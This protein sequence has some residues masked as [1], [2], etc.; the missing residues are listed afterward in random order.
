MN[1][2]SDKTGVTPF[3]KSAF[4]DATSH[5]AATIFFRE[6]TDVLHKEKSGLKINLSL[7]GSL[8]LLKKCNK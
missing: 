5:I 1:N 3:F 4:K 2:V 7:L 6:N 8:K